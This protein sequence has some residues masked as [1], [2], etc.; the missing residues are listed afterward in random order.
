[1]YKSKSKLFLHEPWLFGLQILDESPN[2]SIEEW[3]KNAAAKVEDLECT[4]FG[5]K[6]VYWCIGHYITTSIFDSELLIPSNIWPECLFLDL[7]DTKI[8][9][10][11]SIEVVNTYKKIT[12]SE[13]VNYFKNKKNK[14]KFDQNENYYFNFCMKDLSKLNFPYHQC[15]F[16]FDGLKKIKFKNQLAN[17]YIE[18]NFSDIISIHLRRGIYCNLSK[19]QQYI[20]ELI[21]NIG[22]DNVRKYYGNEIFSS[23]EVTKWSRIKI[24]PDS[25]YFFLIDIILK[26]NPKQKIYI[27]TDVPNYLISHYFKKYPNNIVTK[28]QYLSEFE[29]FFKDTLEKSEPSEYFFSLEQTISNL[30]DFFVLS[31]SKM[32]ISCEESQWSF[33]SKKYKKKHIINSYKMY[34]KYLY[35]KNKMEN[36]L[37]N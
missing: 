6:L 21:I 33:L 34:K 35:R 31:N 28:E 9:K 30:L 4:G 7:P 13:V 3:V 15:D 29:I 22:K 26:N 37:D 20:K 27:S 19:S 16:L 8:S 17:Q 24:L 23:L 32:M 10:L 12:L 5:D 2:F 25:F 11:S 14:I 1:M 18:K 36:I